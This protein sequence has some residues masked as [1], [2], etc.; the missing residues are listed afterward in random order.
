MS[1]YDEL[2][3][4]NEDSKILTTLIQAV[5]KSSNL[6]EIYTVALDSVME[7]ENIDLAMIYLVDEEKS[8]AVLEA[9]RNVSEDYIRRA[10]RIPYPRGI[11][12]KAINSGSIINVE[13]AQQDADTGSAGRDLGHHSNLGIPIF[14]EAR[15]VG[16]IW[17]GSYKERRFDER[18]VSLLSTL[19]DQIAIAI[20]KAKRNEELQEAQKKLEERNRNLSILSA[21]SQAVHQ[22]EDLNQ[23][24]RRV[25]DLTQD[26]KFIDLISLYLIEG[27]KD[28]RQAV[29]QIHRG[30]PEEYLQKASKI[31]YPRGN[32]WRVIESAEAAF[33]EDASDP[34]TPVG[35]A[36]KA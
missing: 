5:H 23:I 15:V 13:D 28:K 17:F 36:G 20:A 35:P 21:V 8:H 12:W 33:Y 14:I 22:S 34:S 3:Q 7:L 29:L 25:L 16:V 11:T 26:L 24:Y 4:A 2:K 31:P 6:E 9:H 19:G 18:E 30:Y 10:G 27:E 1:F 32:T